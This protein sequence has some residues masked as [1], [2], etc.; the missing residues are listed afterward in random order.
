MPRTLPQ[1]RQPSNWL[2]SSHRQPAFQK[3]A[4]VDRYVDNNEPEEMPPRFIANRNF[5]NRIRLP[6]RLNNGN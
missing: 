2:R 1:K 3:P 6:V 5:A 4:E